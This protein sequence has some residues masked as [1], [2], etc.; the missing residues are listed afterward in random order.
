MQ[1]NDELEDNDVNENQS[2]AKRAVLYSPYVLTADK[3]KAIELQVAL[4]QKKIDTLVWSYFKSI[5]LIKNWY[6]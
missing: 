6:I 1:L 3:K 5:V 2:Q 4:W